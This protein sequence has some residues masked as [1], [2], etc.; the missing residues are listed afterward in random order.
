[1]R[2]IYAVKGEGKEVNVKAMAKIQRHDTEAKADMARTFFLI[3]ELLDRWIDETEK[4]PEMIASAPHAK[5]SIGLMKSGLKAL[6]NEVLNAIPLDMATL[7][8]HQAKA[9]RLVPQRRTEPYRDIGFFMDMPDFE[10]VMRL[11]ALQNCKLCLKCGGQVTMCPIR[12]L[13]AKYGMRPEKEVPTSD[14]IWQDIDYE[15]AIFRDVEK[16]MK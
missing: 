15:T 9:I 16:R 8:R 2:I 1:M 10:T 6:G 4:K 12:K 11:I 7:V 13:F 3:Y 5:R 14:C